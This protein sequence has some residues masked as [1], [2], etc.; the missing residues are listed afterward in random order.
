VSLGGNPVGGVLS[1]NGDPSEARA[2]AP[3]WI[4]S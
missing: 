3:L 4:P 2:T 1:E